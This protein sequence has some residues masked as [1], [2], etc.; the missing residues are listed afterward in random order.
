MKIWGQFHNSLIHINRSIYFMFTEKY[1]E[2][3]FNFTTKHIVL[4][5][6]TWPASIAKTKHVKSYF[7]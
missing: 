7:V 4:Q 6:Q 2:G 1:G 3:S 5:C